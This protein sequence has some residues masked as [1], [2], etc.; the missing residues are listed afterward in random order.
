MHLSEG[1]TNDGDAENEAIKYMSEPNPD[2]AHDEPQHIHEY[3]QTSR[4]CWFPLYF[5]TE[6]PD[7][8]HTKFHALNTEWYADDGNHQNQTSD[9]ILQGDV[10]PAKDNPNNVS[11]CLHS[12]LFLKVPDF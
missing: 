5:S 11:Y 10:Q 12:N 6:R 1:Y 4:L 7:S 8:Q 3:A 9:E 2:A